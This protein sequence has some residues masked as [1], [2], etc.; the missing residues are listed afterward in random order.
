MGSSLGW[1]DQLTLADGTVLQ[2]AGS[3]VAD[4]VTRSY[5]IGDLDTFG[6]FL[7]VSASVGAVTVAVEES[8]DG[9]TT[10]TPTYP[11][12]RNSEVNAAVADASVDVHKEWES[13]HNSIAAPESKDENAQ[14]VVYGNR[15]KVRLS[16]TVATSVTFA[17]ARFLAKRTD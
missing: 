5:D 12:G 8:F 14:P 16:F 4:F 17:Q 3:I 1:N 9:E 13:F 11:D 7:E 10:W 2:D 6:V 15:A